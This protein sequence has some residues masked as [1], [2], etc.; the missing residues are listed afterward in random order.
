MQHVER[1]KLASLYLLHETVSLMTC[2]AYVN[3]PKTNQCNA[4]TPLSVDRKF[5]NGRI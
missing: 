5:V 3:K 1:Q 2:N 4:R